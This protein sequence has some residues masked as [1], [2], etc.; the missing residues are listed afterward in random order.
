MGARPEPARFGHPHVKTLF[1]LSRRHADVS[2]RFELGTSACRC[3]C[4]SACRCGC[5]S[6]LRCACELVPEKFL[7]SSEVAHL[8]AAVHIGMPM[9][10]AERAS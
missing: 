10:V 9:C 7:S 3:G 2:V 6:E 1:Q 8:F 4:T 5:T